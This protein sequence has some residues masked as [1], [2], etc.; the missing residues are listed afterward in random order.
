MLFYLTIVFNII[1]CVD[2]ILF[3]IFYCYLGYLAYFITDYLPNNRIKIL[4]FYFLK[5]FIFNVLWTANGLAL[6]DKYFVCL[7]KNFTKINKPNNLII[8]NHI[9]DYDWLYITKSI[10][11]INNNNFNFV[12][13]SDLLKIPVVGFVMKKF[14]FV[15]I[16]RETKV[17]EFNMINSTLKDNFNLILYPEGSVTHYRGVVD[18]NLFAL[19]NTILVNNRILKTTDVIVPRTKGFKYLFYDLFEK[20]NILD[21]TILTNP[22]KKYLCGFRRHKQF[23]ITKKY[24]SSIICIIDYHDITKIEKPD[25]FLYRSFYEKRLLFKKYKKLNRTK[26]TSLKEFYTKMKKINLTEDKYTY[27]EISF[28]N[29]FSFIL[30]KV[31][32]N[33]LMRLFK[34]L[35]KYKRVKKYNKVN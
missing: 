33:I 24:S 34:Y 3:T 11:T 30:Y 26:I 29:E 31:Y 23:W 6:T 5:T 22:Y 15:G 1:R 27:Y 13:K 18:G 17:N 32:F 9:N 19:N 10:S 16:N 2:T 20:I 21:F 35:I 4:I 12:V 7:N 14:G 28:L 8:S 25:D